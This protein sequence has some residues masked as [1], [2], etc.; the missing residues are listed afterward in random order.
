MSLFP[1]ILFSFAFND[2]R[3]F[4]VLSSIGIIKWDKWLTIR[5]EEVCYDSMKQHG[6]G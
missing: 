1:E 5:M 2:K 6:K 4:G 3:P